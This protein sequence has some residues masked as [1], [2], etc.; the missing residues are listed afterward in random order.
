MA[1]DV[2]K[3]EMYSVIPGLFAFVRFPLALGFIFFFL[4]LR[5]FW[6]TYKCDHHVYQPAGYGLAKSKKITN[7]INIKQQLF[8]T[9]N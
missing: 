2:G 7:K 9:V 4:H 8:S 3:V 6:F 5:H 1:Q